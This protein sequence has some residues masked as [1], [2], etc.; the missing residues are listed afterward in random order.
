[1]IFVS[2]RFVPAMA[3]ITGSVEPERRGSYLSV[4]TSIQHLGSGFSAYFSGKI[5][6][7]GADGRLQNFPLIGIL[8]A[9]F[10]LVCWKLASQM[11]NAREEAKRAA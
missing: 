6:T 8:S 7:Q 1:M 5:L 4:S 9:V 3:L 11:M 10:T 2:G